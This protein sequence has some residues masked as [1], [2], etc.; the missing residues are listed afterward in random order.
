MENASKALLIAGAILLVI[1]IIAIG[2]GIVSKT[3]GTMNS[4]EYQ[5]DTMKVQMHNKQFEQYQSNGNNYDKT[6]EEVREL[7]GL[8]ISSNEQNKN[9]KYQIVYL[10]LKVGTNAYYALDNWTDAEKPM[11]NALIDDVINSPTIK[12]SLKLNLSHTNLTIQGRY[13]EARS[14]IDD[15][16]NVN[17]KVNHEA[18]MNVQMTTNRY[19][20]IT[21]IIIT[22]D[23]AH[24]FSV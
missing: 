21:E 11:D 18:L 3:R 5:I 2:I 1:A 12:R 10:T 22:K 6:F 20:Y 15:V 17:P 19:G 8:I 7:A 23:V 13:N 4:A 14:N 16:I 9:N 24:G